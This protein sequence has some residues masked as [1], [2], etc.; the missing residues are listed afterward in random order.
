MMQYQL[1]AIA[2]EKNQ[3]LLDGSMK[4]IYE[5][6]FLSSKDELEF[7][8]PN[9]NLKLSHV[10]S[11]NVEGFNL[12]ILNKEKGRYMSNI[13]KQC[14]DYILTVTNAKARL[15]PAIAKKY[16][17]FMNKLTTQSYKTEGKLR[18]L[19]N[20]RIK[21]LHQYCREVMREAYQETV[22][23]QLLQVCNQLRL[24]ANL[25]PFNKREELLFYCGLSEFQENLPR[26]ILTSN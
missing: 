7:V 22:R 2:V 24:K 20:Y 9:S 13:K 18:I 1:L 8:L 5:L 6:E 23:C 21:L 11:K 14:S 10:L 15:R 16:Q 3:L 12:D 25:L 19:R 17:I 26:A 4:G